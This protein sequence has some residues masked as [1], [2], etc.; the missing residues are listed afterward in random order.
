MCGSLA[1]IWLLILPSIPGSRVTL[2]MNRP[3]SGPLISDW[4]CPCNWKEPTELGDSPPMDSTD[5]QSVIVKTEL[6]FIAWPDG[7]PFTHVL[8]NSDSTF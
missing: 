2:S 7:Q 4:Q 5:H 8:G 3:G 1:R 6:K